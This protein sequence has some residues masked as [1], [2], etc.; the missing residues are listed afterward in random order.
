MSIGLLLLFN[1]HLNS[2]SVEEQGIEIHLADEVPE[3]TLNATETPPATPAIKSHRAFDETATPQ[4]GAPEPL[5]TLQELREEQAVQSA[6]QV[7]AVPSD[8]MNR[9]Q[10][11]ADK[12]KENQQRLH[13]RTPQHKS[14]SD[15][16]N[17]GRSSVS[18][19]LA[20]R[21]A[22]TLP[23]PVYTCIEGGKVVVNITVNADGRVTRAVFNTER[24]QTRNGCLIDNAIAYALK[25]KFSPQTQ[26]S[27]QGTITYLFQAK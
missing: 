20:N 14:F 22:Y 15:T 19:T 17:D 2:S 23:P 5:K 10:Q 12:R 1:I 13:Q 9:L 11:L 7:T 3:E 18:Y 27:Q 8:F 16:L 24:S 4:L 21:E 6:A 25:S 26:K